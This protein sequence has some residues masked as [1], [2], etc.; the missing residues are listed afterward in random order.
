MRHCS[1]ALFAALSMDLGVGLAQA[2]T[3]EVRFIDPA[4]FSDAGSRPGEA[5]GVRNTL[6]GH[7]KSLAARLPQEQS[8]SVDILDID[9]AGRER[10]TRH[11]TELRVLRGRTDWP[12][13]RLRYTLRSGQTMLASGE[14]EITDM[15]YL[16]SPL[17]L[18]GYDSLP[19]E[20]RMLTR[21]FDQRLAPVH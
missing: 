10:L 2:G 7:L 5:E 9:L 16:S 3:A 15:N 17:G 11:G 18:S 20:R 14:E 19:Y 4:S 13:I 8:L 1:L 6:A 12:G 21:W